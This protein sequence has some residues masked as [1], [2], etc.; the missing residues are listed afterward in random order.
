LQVQNNNHSGPKNPKDNL[1]DF[2]VMC[3]KCMK[4][5][6]GGFF[7]PQSKRLKKKK[8]EN[9]ASPALA[10]AEEQDAD[11]TASS[12]GP[13]PTSPSCHLI[14]LVPAACV[15]LALIASRWRH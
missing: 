3:A 2:P 7:L 5:G 8:K 4:E 10:S 9:D 15:L 12:P 11:A 13:S 6:S 1:E 14:I